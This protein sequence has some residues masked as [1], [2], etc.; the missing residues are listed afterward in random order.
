MVMV[1]MRRRV[2][3]SYTSELMAYPEDA[4]SF[5]SAA[6]AAVVRA[7]CLPVHMSLFTSRNDPPAA[8][9]RQQLESCHVYVGL[10]GLRYGTLVQDQPET[11]YV[12]FE[13]D[14]AVEAGLIR[15]VFLLDENAKDSGIPPARVYDSEASSREK[16]ALFRDRLLQRSGLTVGKFSSPIELE[17]KLYQALMEER[18]ANTVRMADSTAR[19]PAPR[20]LFGRNAETGALV[21]AWLAAPP[22]PVAVLGAPGIGKSAICLAAL[23]EEGVQEHFGPRRWFVRCDGAHSAR[24]LLPALA[25]E[26]GVVVEEPGDALEDRIRAVLESG[27]GVLVIDNFETPWHKDAV[28]VEE[29]LRMV[30]SFPGVAVTISARGTGRPPGLRWRDFP[31]IGPLPRCDARMLFLEVSGRRSGSNL[32]LERLL[33][34][35]DGMPLAVE[36]LGYAAQSEPDLAAVAQRWRD[37]RIELLKRMGG[38]RPELSVAASVEA[39]VNSPLMTRPAQRLFGLLGFLPDG[40]AHDDLGA[41]LLVEGQAAASVLRQLGLI[42][43]EYSRVRMLSPIREHARSAYPPD[44]ADLTRAVAHY[45]HMAAVIEDLGSGEEGGRVV[46]R[47]RAETANIAMILRRAADDARIGE[48]VDGMCGLIQYWSLTGTV[49][50]DLLGDAEV[51]V[52]AHGTTRHQARILRAT[53]DLAQGRCQYRDARARYE[54]AL[55]L[56]RQTGDS[57]GVANCLMGIGDTLRADSDLESA[58]AMYSDALPLYQLAGSVLGEANCLKS[59]GNIAEDRSDYATAAGKYSEALP[60]YKEGGSVLGTANCI[61]SLGDMERVR[62]DYPAA[63]ARYEEAIRLYQQAGSVL[64]EANCINGLGNIAEALND[65]KGAQAKYGRALRLFQSIAEPG[66]IG[67]TRVFLARLETSGPAR[68]RHWDAARKAWASIG[69]FDLIE[70]RKA[71]FQ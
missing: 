30:E 57:L 60:L 68:A 28:R 14:K 24:A 9:C 48:L 10:I 1:G 6:E 17:L 69:R 27:P 21:E 15:L 62:R 49:Q 40:I 67:W 51:A 8:I 42:F 16:Q 52:E 32:D 37:E 25:G 56:F 39:S 13:F 22:Q 63:S 71:D 35:L 33:E 12:E 29:L 36:L 3:L 11:S 18:P 34:D 43:D 2:F 61:K 65:F 47:L 58:L 50:Q 23:H 26:L 46:A 55:R 4:A 7:D 66:S 20:N 64:G 54:R 44:P 38:D 19:L 31:E 53:G 45:A 70:S 59:H 5:V 41:L